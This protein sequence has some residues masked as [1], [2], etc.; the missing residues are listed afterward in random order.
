MRKFLIFFLVI[1]AL[2]VSNCSNSPKNV[3]D[4]NLM[5][6][7]DTGTA[8]I[9]FA[10][11]EHDFGKVAEGEK[12]GYTFKFKNTGT[13]ALIINSATTT[14]GCTVPKYSTKPIASGKEG[15]MEVIFDTSG[16]R[17]VQTKTITVSSNALTPVVI[18]RI[19]AEVTQ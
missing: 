12:V 2:V 4:D 15:E 11:Y 8:V 14:C 18:L 9:S 5:S 1:S 16:R 6:H 17:G 3:A 10:G 13:G 7:G 19:I